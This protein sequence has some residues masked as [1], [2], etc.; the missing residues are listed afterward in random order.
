[1]FKKFQFREHGHPW[2][3]MLRETVLWVPY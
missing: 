3:K 2:N 1:M